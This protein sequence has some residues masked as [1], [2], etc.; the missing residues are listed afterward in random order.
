[1]LSDI[2]ICTTWQCI[3]SFSSW[4]SAILSPLIAFISLYIS[5]RAYKYTKE[6]DK[7]KISVDMN[8]SQFLVPSGNR[9]ALSLNVKNIGLKKVVIN[10]YCFS[11][12][13]PREQ[14]VNLT[15]F[16]MRNELNDLSAKLPHHL[17]EGE[18]AVFINRPLLLTESE[19]FNDLSKIKAWLVIK[20]MKVRVDCTTFDFEMSL[21]NPQKKIYGEVI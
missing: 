6:K 11:Y 7:P 10:S 12:K 18:K 1:M 13:L 8:Y 19:I 4:F 21:P 17:N 14:R 9:L 15:T 5:L 3:N 16:H 20:L 2:D